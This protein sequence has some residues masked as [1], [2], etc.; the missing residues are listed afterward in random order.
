MKYMHNIGTLDR[1][2][3]IGISA[4]LIYVSLIDTN[5]IADSLSSGILAVFAIGNLIVAT[6]R[7]CPLYTLVGINTCKLN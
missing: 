7:I 2:L 6:V 4:I 3:R 1:I 5:F